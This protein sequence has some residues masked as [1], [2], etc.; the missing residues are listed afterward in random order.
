MIKGNDGFS[1]QQSINEVIATQIHEK[2]ASMPYTSYV[3]MQIELDEDQVIGC[4]CKNF[5]NKEVEFISAY[6]VVSSVKKRNDRSEYESFISICDLHGLDRKY[7]REF[8]E[9]QILT[10]FIITNTDRH[11]N[12]FGILRDIETLKY[13]DVAPIF[14]SG[15]S[16]LWNC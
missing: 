3:L 2:Q 4:M 1:Y 16:M 10:D 13:V 8:L 11:F 5:T 14:D 6:D 7:V 15:N 9:Y 12:N